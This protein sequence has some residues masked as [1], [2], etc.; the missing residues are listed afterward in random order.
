MMK[1]RILIA[2]GCVALMLAACNRNQKEKDLMVP[3]AVSEL[4]AQ[5]LTDSMSYLL[6]VR[7]GMSIKY[8]NY[9]DLN[10][11][12]MKSG[13]DDA[14]KA[15]G[16]PDIDDEEFASQFDIDP[17]L[18][19]EVEKQFIEKRNRAT[20]L[21]NEIKGRKFLE[22][23]YAAGGVDSTESGLQYKILMKGEGKKIEL[24]DTVRVTMTVRTPEGTI[25]EKTKDEPA[26]MIVT[27][28]R[29]QCPGLLEGL[30]LLRDGDECE[31]VLPSGL[32]G[33]YADYALVG[34][35]KILLID[36]AVEGVSKHVAPKDKK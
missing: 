31:F 4:P 18:G 6:G 24:K 16:F 1:V 27:P 26:E 15:V 22:D 11:P 10:Y 20:G 12:R 3:D 32:I 17:K 29:F 2:A 25:I 33:H 35:N 34:P 36:L 7:I 14:L 21:D 5:S 9:G 28:L 30:Q 8:G 13:I 23:N 19:A